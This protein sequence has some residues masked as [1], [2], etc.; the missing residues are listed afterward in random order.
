MDASWVRGATQARFITIP[1]SHLWGPPTVW[2]AGSVLEVPLLWLE[3]VPASSSRAQGQVPEV[4]G[5]S[6]VSPL[7][8]SLQRVFSPGVLHAPVLFPAHLIW[9]SLATFYF[10]FH[11]KTMFGVIQPS[12]QATDG[13][14]GTRFRAEARGDSKTRGSGSRDTPLTVSDG[15][16]F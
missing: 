2:S 15:V 12:S 10:S 9:S 4:R 11:T 1:S 13:P 16:G 6:Y 5:S 3:L 8:N 7:T 14:W